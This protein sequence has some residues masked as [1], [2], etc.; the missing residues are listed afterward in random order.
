MKVD[1]VPDMLRYLVLTAHASEIESLAV[2]LGVLSL[3]TAVV[4]AEDRHLRF[5]SQV[6]QTLQFP[7]YNLNDLMSLKFDNHT[8]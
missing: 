6:T 8:I 7:H 4:G 2:T 5:K 1:M 3:K